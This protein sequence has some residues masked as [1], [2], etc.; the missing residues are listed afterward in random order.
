MDSH[1]DHDLAALPDLLATVQQ[2]AAGILAG[3]GDR[4]VAAPPAPPV[5]GEPLPRRGA[6]ARAALD[7]FARR[8]GPGFSASAGPRY[9]GF[10]TGGSTP[11][12][13]AGDWLAGV[14]DQNAASGEDS[15]AD[16]LE[17]QA[18]AWL[19]ELFGLTAEHHGAFVS[20]ATVSN[21]TGLAIA[22]EWLGRQHG[23]DVSRS[24][25]TGLGPVP[26]LSG[27]PHSSIYKA[28]SMAGIGRDALRLVPVLLG[29]EAVDVAALEVALRQLDGRPAIVV[30]NAGTVNTGDF[31][32]IRAIAGLRER[33]RFWL[34]VDGAFGAFA[35]LSAEHAGLLDGL[36]EAD[37]VCAD[38]H[39]WL[40][41]PY[42]SAVQFSRHRD[43][44]L[45]VFHNAAAYLGSA[46]DDPDFLH[47]V[48]ENSRRLRA[49]AAWM[50]LTAYGRDGHADIVARDIRCARDLGALIDSCPQLRLL[51]PVRLN[52]VCFTLAAEPT[53]D[54]IAAF[55][56]AVA[57]SGEAFVTPTVYGGTP[58]V[59]AAFSNWRTGPADV[60]QVY[61]VLAKT[62]ALL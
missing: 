5:P 54:R 41:V 17:K 42:D 34:H 13:L 18:I 4:P 50:T 7:A 45:A 2:Y 21:Y 60:E 39:K 52:I 24:G 10:V 43:L 58:A 30:A 8:W 44:Q 23:V 27:T 29:R 48:P 9:L 37:S 11:A 19:C 1:L 38:L 12:A 22:R 16:K 36:D 26:V 53:Q 20:G 33:Y 28:L 32:D 35:A 25:L 56:S 40:N 51:A 14:F 59:R 61:A 15:S 62:A 46:G 55:I 47:L 3:I 57:A 6:G 49:L 31:D